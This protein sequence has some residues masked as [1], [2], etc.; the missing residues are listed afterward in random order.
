MSFNIGE[1]GK[2]TRRKFVKN[3]ATGTAALAFGGKAILRANRTNPSESNPAAQPAQEGELKYRKCF[4]TELHP[5]EREKGFGAQNMFVVFSD[6]DIIEG[7]H[8]FSAMY[9][10]ESATKIAGHGPHKHKEPEVL[11]ALG[12]DPS[13]PRDLG[14]EFE[15]YM[16]AEMEKHVINKSTLIYIPANTIHCPFR[17]TKVQRPFMFIQAQYGL[18]LQE[19]PLRDLVPANMRDKYI[20]IEADG[21]QKDVYIP[22]S[23]RGKPKPKPVS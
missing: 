23:E 10:G 22:P 5:E 20:F 6:N 12:T 15:L 9:M 1:T 2:T 13:N 3:V 19:T 14:A 21:N 17:V 16:G 18:K 7:C 8:F 4:L 11:V